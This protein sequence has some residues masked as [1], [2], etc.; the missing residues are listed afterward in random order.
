MPVTI[1]YAPALEAD[2]YEAVVTG[3]E[4]R[5]SQKTGGSY[6]W[7]EFTVEDGRTISAL[8][9]MSFG[10]RAKAGQWAA[11]LL[12]RTP[13]LNESV[14]LVGLPCLIGVTVNEEGFSEVSTLLGRKRKASPVKPSTPADKAAEQHD[15]E[16]NDGLPF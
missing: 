7:W 9:G 12:G 10:P 8:T 3:L 5:I 16:E 11:A 13:E 4:E 1:K 2:T 15:A 14:E 6:H